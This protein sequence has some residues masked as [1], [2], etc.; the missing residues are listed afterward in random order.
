MAVGK[1][2]GAISLGDNTPFDYAGYESMASAWDSYNERLEAYNREVEGRIFY[3]G[4]P[5][6]ERV[7]DWRDRLERESEALH[8]ER[9][10]L[11]PLFEPLGIVASIEI[12]W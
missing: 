5:Q 4:T 3:I 6:W 7:T 8:R 9:E 10:Q 1:D 2:H 12:Y 11:E